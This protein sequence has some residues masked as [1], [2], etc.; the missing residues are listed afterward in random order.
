MTN[1]YEL[2]DDT[3]A[4]LI[5]EKEDLLAPLRQ[6]MISPPHPMYPDSSHLNYY[7]G[8]ITG[9]HPSQQHEEQK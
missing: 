8:E 9:S 5:F 1:E 6:G 7:K 2:A 3:R 4:K